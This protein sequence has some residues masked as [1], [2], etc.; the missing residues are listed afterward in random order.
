MVL[1][2]G[3]SPV[4]NL[5]TEAGLSTSVSEELTWNDPVSAECRYDKVM[6]TTS[7]QPNVSQKALHKL[8]VCFLRLVICS[9]ELC[10]YI[11]QQWQQ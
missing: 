7:E 2:V 1:L 5:E 3:F 6:D 4:S 10:M 8:V 9:L 11:K